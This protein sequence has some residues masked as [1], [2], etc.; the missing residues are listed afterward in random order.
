MFESSEDMDDSRTLTAIS[1]QNVSML[2]INARGIRL[3]K[4]RRLLLIAERYVASIEK[5]FPGTRRILPHAAS[6]HGYPMKIKVVRESPKKEDF[7]VE[8]SEHLEEVSEF[9]F[10]PVLFFPE[11]FE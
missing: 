11:S 5:A 3:Q 8:V 1:V 2:P 4:I 9:P 7:T 10:L 6:F